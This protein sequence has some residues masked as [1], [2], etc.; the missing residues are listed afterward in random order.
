MLTNQNCPENRGYCRIMTYGP[1]NQSTDGWTDYVQSLSSV[2]IASQTSQTH[3]TSWSFQLM[4]LS[5][6][7]SI[8]L[9]HHHQFSHWT[10]RLKVRQQFTSTSVC[11][12][13][14]GSISECIFSV[15]PSIMCCLTD[16]FAKRSAYRNDCLP[17]V[18]LSSRYLQTS[19]GL[20]ILSARKKDDVSATK[21]TKV[22]VWKLTD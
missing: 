12:I 9:F 1:F 14:S 4:T 10:V 20:I 18:L 15:L 21:G 13:Q 22:E 3:V 8:G 5:T 11:C 6:H 16:W 19:V 2:R 7:E 17:L